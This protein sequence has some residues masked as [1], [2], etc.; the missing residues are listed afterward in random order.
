VVVHQCGR[1]GVG[2]LL[3]ALLAGAATAVTC[4]AHAQNLL[5]ALFG[6]FGRSSAP[7]DAAPQGPESS[8]PGLR[9]TGPEVSAEG[10]G[11]SLA[12]CVR[13]CDGRYFPMQHQN[14]VNPVQLCNSLCPA[15]PTKVFWGSEIGRAVAGDGTRYGSTENALVYRK[16]LVPGCTCNGMTTFGLAPI[17]TGNDPTIRP[18]DVQA[19]GSGRSKR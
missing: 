15:S 12:F 6:N 18:G 11:R 14:G 5:D 17:A 13:L 8:S 1:T 4:Q 3:S 10:H 2:V 19:T 7:Q 16:R 9:P